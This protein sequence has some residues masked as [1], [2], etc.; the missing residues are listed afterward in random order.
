MASAVGASFTVDL[1]AEAAGR[2]PATVLD[3]LDEALGTGLL[4]ETP[5]GFAFAHALIHETVAGSLSKERR[6]RLHRGFAL[7]LEA[8]FE[9]GDD[10][11]VRTLARHWCEAGMRDHAKTADYAGRAAAQATE[12]QGYEEAAGYC[13][14]ALMSLEGARGDAADLLRGPLLVELG[15]AR[16][17]GGATEPPAKPSAPPFAWLAGHVTVTSSLGRRSA[18]AACGTHPTWS[19][20]SCG[21]PWTRRWC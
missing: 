3:A 12:H 20:R 11:V 18:S 10:S 2:D 16:R 8:R 9:A 5:D 15:V 6:R 4:R 1:V 21:P 7:A 13:E 19:T 17:A 14:L